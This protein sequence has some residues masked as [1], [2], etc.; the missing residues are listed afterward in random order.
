MALSY[1]QR[2]VK[3]PSSRYLGLNIAS[4]Q[5]SHRPISFTIDKINAEHAR[6]IIHPNSQLTY[7]IYICIFNK[8]YT[9]AKLCINPLWPNSQLR[10]FSSFSRKIN[11]TRCTYLVYSASAVSFTGVFDAQQ[12]QAASYIAVR[13]CFLFVVKDMGW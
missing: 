9:K 7:G 4:I 10:F 8:L 6:P 13:A 2:R 11:T 5:W 1:L 12:L 3:A